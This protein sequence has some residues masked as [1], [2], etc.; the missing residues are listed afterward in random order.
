M[1]SGDETSHSQSTTTKR[2]VATTM[3]ESSFLV[4]TMVRGYHVYKDIWTAAVGEELTCRREK[5][6][7]AD[8]F[9]VA[10]VKEETTVGHVPRKTSSIC[11]LFLR[12]NGTILCQIVGNRRYSGDLP[13][14]GLEVPCTLRFQSNAKDVNNVKRII[15]AT[16]ATRSTP[17]SPP[18][19]KRKLESKPSHTKEI[20]DTQA[21]ETWVRL[22]SIVLTNRDKVCITGGEKLSDLH[23]NFAQKLLK[24]QFLDLNGLRSTLLQSKKLPLKDRKQMVQIVHSHGDHWIVISTINADDGKVNV[25]DSVYHMQSGQRYNKHNTQSI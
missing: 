6:N 3:T 20:E 11:S 25:Y 2:R 7:A 13:Q 21:S 15:E 18:S 10:V 24:M 5:F 23:I 14:G 1:G 8:P 4:D 9:A 12:R 16:L 22:G 17:L 19:K